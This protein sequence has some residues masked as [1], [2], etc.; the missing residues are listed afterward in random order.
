MDYVIRCS[1]FPRNDGFERICSERLTSG[2]SCANVLVTLSY[3][4]VS[5]SLVAQVGEDPLG[6]QFR[7]ELIADGVCDQWLF[8]RPGGSTMHTYV[9]VSREGGRA[10]LV[11]PGDSYHLLSAGQITGKMLDGVSVL[12]TDGSPGAP[13]LKLCRMAKEREIP[14]FYQMENLPS[15][16]HGTPGSYARFQE[17]LASADLICAGQDVYREL[18]GAHRGLDECVKSLWE[19]ISPR[20]GLVCTAGGQG[21]FWYDGDS[22]LRM[23]VFPVK[24]IDTTGAGDSFCGGLILRYL[25]ED[26]SREEALRF[27]CACGAMKCLAPGPRLRASRQEVEDFMASMEGKRA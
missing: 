2:G 21:A 16:T 18:G 13:A 6:E 27:A 26:A 3:L 9:F 7:R 24:A 15:F 14:V 17:I 10:I 12:F 20:H 4:G 5:T 22:F 19:T 8:V 25:L 11:N 1:G 23:P